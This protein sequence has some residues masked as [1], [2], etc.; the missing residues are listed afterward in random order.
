MQNTLV[1]SISFISITPGLKSYI[2]QEKGEKL[3]GPWSRV[4]TGSQQPSQQ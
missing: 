1:F 2:S 3:I 4:A